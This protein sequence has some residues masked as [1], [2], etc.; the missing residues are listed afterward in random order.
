MADTFPA[1]TAA[2]PSW[3]A[4]VAGPVM[5]LVGVGAAWGATRATQRDHG[6]RLDTLEQDQGE[7]FKELADKID[8]NHREV[9]RHIVNLAQR[10]PPLDE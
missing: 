10:R 7:G 3:W 4:W 5:S 1:D 6:R 9:M 8:N 2:V